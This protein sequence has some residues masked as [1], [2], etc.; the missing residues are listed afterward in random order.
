MIITHEQYADLW[1]ARH[2]FG[3]DGADRIHDA[4]V[5]LMEIPAVRFDKKTNEWRDVEPVGFGI[6]LARGHFRNEYRRALKV[7]TILD[8][9][10]ADGDG[11]TMA[12]TLASGDAKTARDTIARALRALK[13]GERQIVRLM[14]HGYTQAEIADR[15]RLKHGTFRKRLHALRARVGAAE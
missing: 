12:E 4:V 8:A 1:N 11:H 7:Q 6:S 15:L 5:T 14:L 3:Q 13:P 2:R 10:T 9:P